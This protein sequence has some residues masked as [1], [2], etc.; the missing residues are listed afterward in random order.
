MVYYVTGATGHLGRSL[1]LLLLEE[2]CSIVALKL[3]NDDHTDFGELGKKKITWV[4]GDITK[5]DDLAKFFGASSDPE[6]RLFH[7]AGV[8][9]IYKKKDPRVMKVNVE[10]TK[11]VIEAAIKRNV[12]RV[13]Y[14]GSVDAI[15]KPRKGKIS[16]P[17]S[18]DPTPLDGIYGKSKAIAS[19]YLLSNKSIE[20]I[21]MMPSVI[22]GPNDLFGGPLNRALDSFAKGKLKA[23]V[24][25]GYDLVDVRDVAEGLLLAM[26]YGKPYSSYILSGHSI[27]I[28]D[29]IKECARITGLPS[30]KICLPASFVKLFAPM[31]E[32]ISKM[33]HEKPLFTAYSMECLLMNHDCSYAK[34]K[35]ELS[36]SPRPLEETLKDTF[37]WL[38]VPVK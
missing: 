13:V 11:K 26:K 33:K 34:A 37:K 8:I 2:D 18:F 31:L 27:S 15:N 28:K 17:T 16:E 10:G 25:G 4:D 22:L 14:V 29:L 35:E 5:D 3:S 6:A 12:K 19:S 36:Y 24:T 21:V 9:T 38:N 30:Y 7:I 1:L 23:I 32:K 20:S